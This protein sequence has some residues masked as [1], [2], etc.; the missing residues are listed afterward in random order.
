MTIVTRWPN[1]ALLAGWMATACCS[2]LV[3]YLGIRRRR[4]GRY[5]ENTTANTAEY[6]NTITLN[7]FCIQKKHVADFKHFINIYIVDDL[8]S[9]N[10]LPLNRIQG[11]IQVLRKG[12]GSNIFDVAKYI[13]VLE[14]GGGGGGATCMST[15][16]NSY[17]DSVILETKIFVV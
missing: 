16:R 17:R 3:V 6:V 8:N 9:Q 10:G 15:L 4:P 14:V 2:I 7:T 5:T 12:G 11:R 13:G 1:G